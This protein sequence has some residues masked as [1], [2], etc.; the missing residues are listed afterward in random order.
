MHPGGR[1]LQTISAGMGSDGA[2]LHPAWL[3]R[4]R[5]RHNAGE[6]ISRALPGST[7]AKDGQETRGVGESCAMRIERS[8][9]IKPE[10]ETAALDSC[11]EQ[12]GRGERAHHGVLFLDA[13]NFDPDS[14]SS[15]GS[16]H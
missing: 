5:A 14:R 7:R 6:N 13:T 3:T 12:A 2:S 16:T 15:A 10:L 1:H 9:Q 8:L 11:W 4:R